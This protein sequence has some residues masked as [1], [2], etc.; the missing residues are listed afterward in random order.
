[1]CAWSIYGT[2]CTYDVLWVLSLSL[3]PSMALHPSFHLHPSL[4][5]P[6]LPLTLHLSSVS[7]RMLR[8]EARIRRGGRGGYIYSE[9]FNWAVSHRYILHIYYLC[10]YVCVCVYERA[11]VCVCVWSVLHPN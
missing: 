7:G 3:H 2:L 10:V 11:R 6:P 9:S 1:M 5:H 8:A 4:I